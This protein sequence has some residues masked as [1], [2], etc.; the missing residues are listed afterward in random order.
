MP[1]ALQQHGAQQTP[2]WLLPMHGRQHAAGWRWPCKALL[3]P[4][5]HAG[6]AALWQQTPSIQTPPVSPATTDEAPG[7]LGTWRECCT[8]VIV[9]AAT[10][11]WHDAKVRGQKYLA[12]LLPHLL[13]QLPHLEL[14]C[15][16]CRLLP[17]QQGGAQLL[18]LQ[19]IPNGLQLGPECLHCS[20]MSLLWMECLL[21]DGSAKQA[22]TGPQ[23]QGGKVSLVKCHR[24]DHAS[25]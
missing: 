16:S 12:D 22:Q 13:S 25:L 2:G 3:P 11:T 21:P 5:H 8:S 20:S 19:S 17:R 23:S 15:C 1:C 18:L 14:P 6:R 7:S 9:Q 10:F 24:Q 4:A